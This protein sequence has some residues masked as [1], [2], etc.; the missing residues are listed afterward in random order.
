MQLLDAGRRAEAE[1]KFDYATQLYR[2]LTEYYAFTSEAA[3]ARNGLGR[4]GTSAP[5]WGKTV[6]QRH[7]GQPRSHTAARTVPH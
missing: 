1:G 6:P 7:R 3:E 5:M 4:I 2:H